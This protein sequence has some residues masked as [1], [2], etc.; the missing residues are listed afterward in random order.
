MLSEEFPILLSVSG[1]IRLRIRVRVRVSSLI[2][3]RVRV[4]LSVSDLVR[5]KVRVRVR[6]SDLIQCPSCSR[7]FAAHLAG[8]GLGWGNVD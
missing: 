6:V 8:L 7:P 2:R 1:L 3:V 4:R 5:V